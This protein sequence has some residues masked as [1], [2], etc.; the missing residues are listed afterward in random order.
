M[1]FNSRNNPLGSFRILQAGRL[2]I[3][4]VD[5][6][7]SLPA[8]KTKFLQL[9]DENMRRVYPEDATSDNIHFD[10]RFDNNPLEV[11]ENQI[12][13]LYEGHAAFLPF[14]VDVYGYYEN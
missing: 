14:C 10:F 9:Y 11:S 13:H 3:L 5:Y 8:G 2:V 7:P 12:F 4:R 1:C 6:A